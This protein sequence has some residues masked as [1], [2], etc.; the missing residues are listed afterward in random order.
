MF[1]GFNQE[2]FNRKFKT[3][4]DCREFL[5]KLKWR[6]GYCCK[7][8]GNS[9]FWKG[10]T[11]FHARCTS[12]DYDESVTANTVFHKCKIPL[13]KAFIITFQIT[14][15]KKGVSCR[16]LSGIM[17]VGL[18]SVW[19]FRR[20]VQEVMGA[21]V[22]EKK[23][24]LLQIRHC[25]VDG[26][27][28]TH[29][30]KNLNGLQQVGLILQ[31]LRTGKNRRFIRCISS[32]NDPTTFDQCT[33]LAGRY[34]NEGKELLIW[35]LRTWLTGTHHHCSRKYL[36][37]YLDEFCFRTNHSGKENRIWLTLISTMMSM[38][39]VRYIFNGA[40]RENRSA[41]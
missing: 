11:K 20:K 8:C 29:R 38:K 37:G 6:K 13:L 12:C 19:E 32:D 31:K 10:R 9:E 41:D 35:N 33:L 2:K 15:L 30:E 14:E 22:S 28:L 24:K 36:K 7:R 25:G 23:H 16:N 34:V 26:I 5:F 27:I 1:K 21:W 3:N 17:N 39:P 18:K 4:E 40:K